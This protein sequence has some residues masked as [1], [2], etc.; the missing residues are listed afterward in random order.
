MQSL[1]PH[2]TLDRVIMATAVLLIAGAVT[3]VEVAHPN[4]KLSNAPSKTTAPSVTKTEEAKPA[5]TTTPPAPA[6]SQAEPAAAA[7]PAP[8]PKPAAQGRTATTVSFVHVRAGKATTT[9]IIMDLDGGV[10][11]QLRT[12]SNAT[13]QGVT[14]NG[15]NGYIYKAYLQY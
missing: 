6:A 4:L 9:P 13:W 1:N 8:A 12:D 11:V 2:M 3:Y 15:K 5:V 7:V 14:V 10:T